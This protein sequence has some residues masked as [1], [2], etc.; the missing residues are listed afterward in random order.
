[1]SRLTARFE[2]K[3]PKK[4]EQK[5]LWKILSQQNKL[6]LKA[7]E[8]DELVEAFPE[9]TGRDIKNLLKLAIMV[10]KRRETK[11]TIDTLRE[12]ERFKQ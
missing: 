2:Y 5:M 1:M 10:A 4:R 12:I 9:V 11:L 6:K 8:L 7:D 3:K